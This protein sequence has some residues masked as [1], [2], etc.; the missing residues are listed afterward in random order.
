M[1]AERAM[2]ARLISIPSCIAIDDPIKAN[3][4]PLTP[5]EIPR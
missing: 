5:A 4:P 2:A 1:M 3:K